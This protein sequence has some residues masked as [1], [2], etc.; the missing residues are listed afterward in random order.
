M[1]ERPT[2][3]LI[4]GLFGFDKLLW[5][6]YFRGVRALY[7][8]MGLRVLSP[9]LPWAG[10]IEQ[11][12]ASLAKQLQHEQGPLH[13]LAHSMGGIDARYWLKYL[14]GAGKTASLTTLL[15]PHRGSPAADYVCSHRSAF[16]LLAGVHCLTTA[17]MA[18]FNT[19]TPNLPQI[20]YRSYSATRPLAEQPWL[21]RRYARYIQQQQGD[22]DAQVSVA[23][24]RW[25]THITTLPCDHYEI[26]FKNLWLNPLRRRKSF[27]PIPVYRDIAKWILQQS[28]QQ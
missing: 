14:G 20:I 17:N 18:E 19:R 1:N 25:G 28:E 6:E 12:A 4:H 27:D 15:T 23:S 10:S 8:A 24:A 7:E 3:V 13:L 16:R 9:R 22:N 11:R 21:V 2:V 5:F 26:I